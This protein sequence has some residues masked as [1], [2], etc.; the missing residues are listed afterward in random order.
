MKKLLFISIVAISFGCT[1][2]ALKDSNQIISQL[3][4]EMTQASLLQ[5]KQN[6]NLDFI[7]IYDAGDGDFMT[8]N[9]IIKIW[10]TVEDDYTL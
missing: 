8:P 5:N 3:K 10:Y 2:E 4:E 7:K 1:K 9:M 6:K